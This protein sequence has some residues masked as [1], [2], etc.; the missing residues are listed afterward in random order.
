M[1]DLLKFG[2]I[3]IGLAVLAYT[4]ALLRQELARPTPRRE[5]RNLILTFMAFSLV[6]FCIAAFIEIREKSISQYSETKELAS[7]VASIASSLDS[8]VGSKFQTTVE[9]LPDGSRE[10]NDLKYFTNVLCSDVKNLK[11][12]IGEN[13]GHT[14]CSAH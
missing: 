4:A 14:S 8:N 2:A 10:K 9:G 13:S 6:A 5:A 7:R 12:A 1:T 3:G 11:A